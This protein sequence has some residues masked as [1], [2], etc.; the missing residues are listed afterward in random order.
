MFFMRIISVKKNYE[1]IFRFVS[2]LFMG[3]N[4]YDYFLV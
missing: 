1:N 4:K 2:I 3:D